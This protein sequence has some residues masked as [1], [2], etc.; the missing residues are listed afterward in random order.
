MKGVCQNCFCYFDPPQ[1]FPRADYCYLCISKL[2][3][4]MEPR[5]IQALEAEV[6]RAQHAEWYA[7][8]ER[9]EEAAARKDLEKDLEDIGRWILE[10]LAKLDAPINLGAR[11]QKA[12]SELRGLLH[13][14]NK[15]LGSSKSL[16]EALEQIRRT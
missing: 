4:G 12:R 9:Q 15:L 5:D 7:E 8:S 13:H 6:E 16:Q 3:D 1:E 10:A 11:V 2:T 14:H